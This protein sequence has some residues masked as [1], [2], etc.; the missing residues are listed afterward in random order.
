[1][2]GSAFYVHTF[3][4]WTDMKTGLLALLGCV[5]WCVVGGG[6]ARAE[7]VS[8]SPYIDS[9]K[10]EMREDGQPTESTPVPGVP[11]PYIQAAK[12]RL[13]SSSSST[14]GAGE[15]YTEELKAELPPAPS[16][17]YTEEM[18]ARLEPAP[19][20]SAIQAVLEGRSDLKAKKVG[21]VHHAAG[22]RMGWSAGRSVTSSTGL[23]A[24]ESMY[25]EGKPLEFDL[26]YEYQPWR[27]DWLG[28]VGFFG[29]AGV[30][31]YS[32][33]GTFQFRVHQAGTTDGTFDS[34]SRT[35]FQFFSIPVSLGVAYRLNLLKFVRP[36][37]MA[38]GSAVGFYE[39]RNDGHDANTATSFGYY[40]SG[41][42]NIPMDWISASASWDLYAEHGV[43]HY[44]LSL[45]YNKNQTF[46]GDLRF[47]VSSVYGGFTFEF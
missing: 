19:A 30:G 20:D 1:V 13:K 10:E 47:D 17:S 22:L 40:L 36:F 16:S 11:D 5:S 43:K 44:Y 29:Q 6:L 26:F 14:G 23:Q 32:G 37:V 2:V 9:L 39:Q 34:K 4:K 46:T 45:A 27:S 24:F 41:G 38:G 18:K 33:T 8:N 15:S 25:G 31:Y 21:E 12:E 35:K 28:S 3:G 42:I 7:T